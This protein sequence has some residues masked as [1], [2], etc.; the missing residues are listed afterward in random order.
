MDRNAL[1][2]AVRKITWAY[3]FFYLDIDLGTIDILPDWVFFILV[4]RALPDLAKAAPSAM[5]LESLSLILCGWNMIDWFLAIFQVTI[6]F[7]LITVVIVI[8]SLYFH[9]QLLTNLAHI[10]RQADCPQ[11]KALLRL[12]SVMTVLIT[13]FFVLPLDW[14]NWGLGIAT[15]ATYCLLTIFLCG[16]LYGFRKELE[17]NPMSSIES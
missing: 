9:F 12:R 16:A 5:L 2:A 3:V 10:A 15:L 13:V 11:E 4:L 1:A 6:N 7:Y 14:L 17:I 8:L